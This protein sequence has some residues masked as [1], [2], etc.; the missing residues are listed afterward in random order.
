MKQQ[1]AEFDQLLNN[2]NHHETMSFDVT[3]PIVEF[4]SSDGNGNANVDRGIDDSTNA[5]TI[6]MVHTDNFPVS[7]IAQKLH[8]DKDIVS[9]F[10][11]LYSKYV[12]E[13]DA[14]FMINISS[15]NRKQLKLS[16][17]KDY[18]CQQ[19]CH[20]NDLSNEKLLL[21]L[22]SEMDQAAF[23]VSELMLGSFARFQTSITQP[24]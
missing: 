9:A 10:E 5:S 14:A 21:K 8:N 23:E 15:Q 7:L 11:A 3:L 6:M 12:D 1:F 18:Y 4:E 16:L 22:I 17:D 13:K 20:L 19:N 2:P 24:L